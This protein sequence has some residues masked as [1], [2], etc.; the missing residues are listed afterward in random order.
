MVEEDDLVT[1]SDVNLGGR[2]PGGSSKRSLLEEEL[3]DPEM[4]A[5]KRRVAQRAQHNPLKPPNYVAPSKGL[6]VGLWL[7]FG[8]IGLVVLIIVM[9]LVLRH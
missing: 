3:H 2:L 6:P 8:G 1:S 5:I 4:D 9:M 7:L